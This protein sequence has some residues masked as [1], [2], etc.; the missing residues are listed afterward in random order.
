VILA[1]PLSA[2]ADAFTVTTNKDIYAADEKAI[3][4]GLLPEDAPAGHAVLIKVTGAKGD[5]VSQNI[6]PGVDSGFR[7]KP[8]ALDECGAGQFTVF[9]YYADLK[10]SST[11]TISNSSQS[12]EGSKL[13][14]RTLKKVILQALDAINGQVKELIEAGYVLP[15]EVADKY[16]EGV[17][18]ASLALEAIEFGDTA[19][20]KKHMILAMQDLREV[21]GDLSEE[22]N[23]RFEQA[24]REDNTDIVGTYNMLERKYNNL[25]NVAEKNHIDKEVEFEHSG[26]LLSDAKQMIQEGNYDGAEHRL[27]QVNAILE[28]ITANLYDVEENEK[29]ASNA[30]ASSPEDEKK[31]RDLARAAGKFERNVLR[32]LNQTSDSDAL[33]H[34][35]EALL[36][37]TNARGY[38]NA[39]DLDSA[40]D[41][42]AQ[43]YVHIEGAR[44]LIE[45]NAEAQEHGS[46]DESS[47][48]GN[49]DH[50][51]EESSGHKDG[52]SGDDD[53]KNEYEDN[54]DKQ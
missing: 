35:Q 32:L 44:H 23:A 2:F 51:S 24:E 1:I 14:L 17:S 30:N 45:D 9:A 8:V 16:G 6:L 38:I 40:K 4:V 53:D 10:A 43:A 7:S 18:E 36:L 15:E 41:T 19:E 33:A 26:R 34:L 47:N 46:S 25:Q 13:E 5:C 42:L 21:R 12:D 48:G 39:Q 52:Y 54:E 27:E 29:F 49:S 20:A 22:N 50:D 31:A 28:E 11:F 3:I 37:I